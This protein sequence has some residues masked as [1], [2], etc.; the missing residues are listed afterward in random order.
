MALY[1]L[2]GFSAEEATSGYVYENLFP[3]IVHINGKGVTDK[4]TVSDDVRSVTKIDVMRLKAD[5]PAFRQIGAATN[6]GY[7]NSE[8]VGYGGNSP[9]SVQYTIGVDLFY[10]RMTPI[11]AAQLFA[12]RTNFETIVQNQIVEEMAWG[13]NLVTFA[14]QI[15]GFFRNGD[16]FDKALTHNK[17][18][19]V[20]GDITAGE[21]AAAVYHYDPTVA[22]DAA[23]KFI[24]A[25]ASL[26]DGIP[27]I[28]A[29]VVPADARQ[30]FVSSAFNAKLKAQYSSNASEAAA[31]INATGFMNPFTQTEG[32]RVDTK[33][34]LCGM[35]DGVGMYLLNS[36]NKKLIYIYLGILGTGA[37]AAGDK[38][39]CR[40]ALDKL[41]GMIVYGA[42]TCRGIAVAPTVAVKDDPFNAQSV[43]ICP[44]A[45]VGV[46]VLHGATIKFIVNGGAAG[47]TAWAAADVA[48]LMNTLTFTGIQTATNAR[49]AMANYGFNN[50]TTK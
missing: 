11:P 40:T 43:N 3:S 7:A 23:V 29:Y 45:K 10:D 19:I 34:G 14:K 44:L 4:Y 22:N 26:S 38:P 39:A 25:N 47:A 2:N 33:T 35:Y 41:D 17:G 1:T 18:A 20:A 42:G 28:G 15:E 9:Q 32:K 8:N 16:N 12:N 6:G 5:I 24:E 36:T 37:D 13:I 50:G 31:Q 49:T 30:A 21:L 46:D 48:K 27:E